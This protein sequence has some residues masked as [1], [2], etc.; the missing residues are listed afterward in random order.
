M[1]ELPTEC[2]VRVWRI[3]SRKSTPSRW[4]SGRPPPTHHRRLFFQ[5]GDAACPNCP[6][7]MPSSNMFAKA[8]P[9]CAY[10]S[11]P[12]KPGSP[13]DAP[14]R[15]P[16]LAAPADPSGLLHHLDNL[17]RAMPPSMGTRSGP[18]HLR[19]PDRPARPGVATSR[20]GLKLLPDLP[21]PR[22]KLMSIGIYASIRPCF[23]SFGKAMHQ[24]N[25]RFRTA[26]T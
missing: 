21:Q 17:P 15:L 6:R 5:S 3:A 9:A 13:G 14:R 23:L 8:R 19:R 16:Q 22:S 24:P 10:R 20:A 25:R 7:E 12:A 11:T 1:K 4:C 26:T 2:G 18:H